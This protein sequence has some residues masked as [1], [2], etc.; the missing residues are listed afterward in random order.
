MGSLREHAAN[1]VIPLQIIYL[2]QNTVNPIRL[3][4]RMSMSVYAV[5]FK[6]TNNKVNL[7]NQLGNMGTKAYSMSK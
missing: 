3:Y 2:I 4:N 6:T 1:D 5:L 7:D